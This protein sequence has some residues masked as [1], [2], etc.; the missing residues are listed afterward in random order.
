VADAMTEVRV[1]AGVFRTSSYYHIQ[2]GG[3]AHLRGFVG[4]FLWGTKLIIHINLLPG[5]QSVDLYLLHELWKGIHFD[6]INVIKYFKFVE[7]HIFFRK[8][9]SC[10]I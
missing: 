3:R 4:S 10:F 1:P 7:T 5:L 8:T 6:S 2:D 9:I